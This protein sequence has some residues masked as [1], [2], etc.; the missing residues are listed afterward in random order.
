MEPRQHGAA[1][2]RAGADLGLRRPPFL[3]R[4][5]L[6]GATGGHVLGS[7][8][9][10]EKDFWT[11]QVGLKRLPDLRKQLKQLEQAVRKLEQNAP[12]ESKPT[13]DAA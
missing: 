2:P 9:I 3:E 7:P 1:G 8:A 5:D 4:S 12:A 13:A 11:Q 10:P 6:A